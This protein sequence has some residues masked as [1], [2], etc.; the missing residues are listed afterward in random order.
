MV[1]LLAFNFFF[2]YSIS[3]LLTLQDHISSELASNRV[4]I[5]NSNLSSKVRLRMEC[6]FTESSQIGK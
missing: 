2:P 5:E 3:P 6:S 4:N 1:F